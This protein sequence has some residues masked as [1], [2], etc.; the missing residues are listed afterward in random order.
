[1][2]TNEFAETL[3]MFAKNENTIMHLCAEG[4]SYKNIVLTLPYLLKQYK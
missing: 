3:S 2:F 4:L 1:V